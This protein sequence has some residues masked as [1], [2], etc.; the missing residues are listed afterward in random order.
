MTWPEAAIYMVL[1]AALAA[2]YIAWRVTGG[3]HIGERREQETA[4]WTARKAP[5]TKR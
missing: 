5:G 3:R 1:I 4:R 2:C